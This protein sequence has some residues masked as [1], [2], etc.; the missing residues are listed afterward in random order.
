MSK[1]TLMTCWWRFCAKMTTWTTSKR[2]ST[3]FG[4]ITWSWIQANTCV[5][6]NS[7]EIL[8]LHGIPKRHRSQPGESTS[9]NGV[10]ATE[11]G[12]K[13]VEFEWQNHGPKQVC[14][15][16]NKQMFTFLLHFEEIVW[17]DGQVPEGIRGLEEIPFV[18]TTTQL[19]Q[20]RRRALLVHSGFASN[21]QRGPSERGGRITMTRLFCK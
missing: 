11:N 18:S 9:H 4:H 5:R 13:S 20:T 17:V 8:G 1:F 21:G 2:H 14:L 19:V 6:G 7:W 15:Q 10:R 16:S 3:P 12:E